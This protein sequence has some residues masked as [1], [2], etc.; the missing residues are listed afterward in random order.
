MRRRRG[1][2]PGLLPDRELFTKRRMCERRIRDHAGLKSAATIDVAS[3]LPKNRALGPTYNRT[4]NGARDRP[5]AYTEGF[6]QSGYPLTNDLPCRRFSGRARTRRLDRPPRAPTAF[7]V[8]GASS[9]I[10]S[11][12]GTASRRRRRHCLDLP[13]ST[14]AYPPGAELLT[15]ARPGRSGFPIHGRRLPIATLFLATA[16]AASVAGSSASTLSQVFRWPITA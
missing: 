14:T 15:R 8:I 5:L 9:T 3:R 2:R 6:M 11:E 1:P 12:R 13:R 16:G 7:G 4:R 10:D